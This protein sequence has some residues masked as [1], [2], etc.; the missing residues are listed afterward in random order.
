MS[1]IQTVVVHSSEDV[2]NR[3][4]AVSS[5]KAYD[6]HLCEIFPY[7]IVGDPELV[8][9]FSDTLGDGYS[10]G[11]YGPFWPSFASVNDGR[12]GKVLWIS[13]TGL[14]CLLKKHQNNYIF[15]VQEGK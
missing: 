2:R 10:E 5:V 3:L 6:K 12:D 1:E 14:D 9:E 8:G 7:F 15:D 4:T 11:E 13:A